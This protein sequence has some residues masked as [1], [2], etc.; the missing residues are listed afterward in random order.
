MILK[1][2]KILIY[3]Y[4]LIPLFL[5]TGPALPDISITIFI[6]IIITF[7]RNL[8]TKI[9]EPW[10]FFLFLLWLWFLFISFFAYNFEK[11]IID[12]IIFCRF[13]FFI[14]L[15]FLIFDYFDKKTI[16]N[17]LYFILICCFFVSI[18]CLYQFYNYSYDYGF[19]ADILGRYPEGLYGR[20][21][22]PFNDLV[23]G[24]YLSRLLFFIFILFF[25]VNNKY[26]KYK[27]YIKCFFYISISLILIVIY[28]SGE[29][30]ALATVILGYLICFI[31]VKELRKLTL[32]T[33]FGAIS[34]I[35][36]NINFHP[37]FTNTVILES[38]PS[39]EGLVIQ[40]KFQCSDDN[41]S[42]CVKEFLVQPAFTE[43][44]KNFDKSA[45]GE[46]YM[47]AFHMWSDYKITGI[48][49]NN[50]NIL[51]NDNSKFRKYNKNFGC[52]THPHNLYI[53]ALVE[54]GLI[55]LIIFVTVVLI[56]FYKIYLI[57]EKNIKYPLISAY[58]TIFWPIMSTGSF[59]KN[60]NM[61][62][63]CFII[64]LCFIISKYQELD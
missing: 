33:T 25:F 52:T 12:A 29:R 3:L 53:Q 27:Y 44:L 54:T 24:S 59:L 35:V 46:I 18:D 16:K 6:L 51:C 11:S 62:F 64:S 19:G 20:L 55:G 10:M 58:L 15:S 30:M 37:H 8:I 26:L 47:S 48:G 40:K 60:W 41:K 61:V 57:E 38:K 13:I 36:I 22:G 32:I 39:H 21:S 45:Y 9:N 31:F 49:L 17:L 5:I 2:E 4:L 56:M 7:K 50:F 43:V 1:S 34:F 23:P 63:I 28:F 42:I 14:I